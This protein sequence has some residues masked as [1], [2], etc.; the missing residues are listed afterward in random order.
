M[1]ALFRAYSFV[2]S[3]YTLAP[4]SQ[5]FT[6]RKIR[7]SP[8]YTPSNLAQ[9]FATVA[10]KLDVFPWLDYHFAYSLGN[11]HKIDPLGGYAW[12]NL[13]M[14]AKFSGKDDE[15]GFIMLH[16]DINQYSPQLIEAVFGIVNSANDSER[17]TNSLKLFADTLH[18]M[19]DRR[20]LMWE[21][22]RWKHYNDFRVFIMGIKG[23]DDIFPNGLLYEGVWE[24]PKAFR[25]QT[26]AQD[27]IIPTA[28][29]VSGV[30]DYYP[31]N[32]LTKY[33]LDL[34]QYRPKCVQHF[35]HDLEKTM[36]E[37][38]LMTQLI[39][40]NNQVGMIELMR[41]YEEIYLFRN[42][43]WQ[44]CK[45]IMQNTA[46]PKATGGTPITSWI[47]NQIKAVLGAAGLLS[48]S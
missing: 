2:A 6:N 25:G 17:L 38:P 1:A 33:L 8:R 3:A 37:K 21:A 42:G 22:S 5:F 28:D 15:R 46:Y 16:V 34:R 48:P 18:H 36:K 35:F 4:A 43:H 20:K 19:N 39:N 44:L 31:Q 29:I 30:I 23:N 32:Q 9:P 12:T 41:A 7:Q 11:Y 14:S 45:Y 40:T 13:E 26:G 27:N 24:E 10:Q 47:P